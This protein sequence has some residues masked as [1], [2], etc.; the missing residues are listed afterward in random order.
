MASSKLTVVNHDRNATGMTYVYPVVSRRAGGVS[1]GVNLNPNNACNWRCVYCQVPN[2]APG[3]A[4][5]IDLDLLR[6]ELDAML[7]DVVHGDFMQRRVPDGYRR[8]NDVALS[9]NGEP[10][11]SPQIG[12][13]IEL[14]GQGLAKVG[15]LGTV[16][17]VL[18]TNG[19]MMNKAFVKSALRAL[20]D[21]NGEVWF[22]LDAGTDDGLRRI[23]GVATTAE[24]HL[25]RLAVAAGLCPTWI[26]TCVFGVD[27]D[28]PAE[29]ELDAYVGRLRELQERRVPVRGVHLYTLARPSLQPEGDAL[30]A[31]PE[32]WLENL[33]RR[34][35]A[36][37]LSVKVSG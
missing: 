8:F 15:R 29:G 21:L 25:D 4:P 28:W 14:V 23:N 9:G 26:Q 35:E 32:P 20:A 37:G 13:V 3:K 6:R 22:K 1:I 24:Q 7:E 16:K 17:I 31:V 34:I 30:R 11:T 27:G 18:I 33:A 10:T 12:D 5:A 36:T 19:S 2:L